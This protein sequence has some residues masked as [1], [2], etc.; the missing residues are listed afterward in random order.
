MY[1]IVHNPF[2]QPTG[3]ADPEFQHAQS[4]RSICI[5]LLKRFK[6]LPSVSH[7]SDHE[8]SEQQPQLAFRIKSPANILNII[9]SLASLCSVADIPF[10]EAQARHLF[11]D[12]LCYVAHESEDSIMHAFICIL[13]ILLKR[14][15]SPSAAAC[16]PGAVPEVSSCVQDKCVTANAL[17]NLLSQVPLMTS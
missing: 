12:L 6:H 8:P 5:R 14:L 11:H 16:L 7:G 4:L 13:Q 9:W 15:H 1:L 10:P 2:L 3:L 17:L